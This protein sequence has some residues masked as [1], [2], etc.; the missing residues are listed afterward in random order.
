[1]KKSILCALVL[2]IVCVCQ[3]TFAEVE[4]TYISS[5]GIDKTS[6][7]LLEEGNYYF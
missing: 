6:A 3:S 2:L 1:M 5:A 4:P 7:V